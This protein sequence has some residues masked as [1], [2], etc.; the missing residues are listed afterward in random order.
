[1]AIGVLLVLT[2]SVIAWVLLLG[3]DD[4]EAAVPVGT[5]ADPRPAPV[6]T[7]EL[8]QLAVEQ[9]AGGAAPSTSAPATAAPATTNAAEPSV[10]PSTLPEG[11]A[12]PATMA[13]PATTTTETT[14]TTTETTT[15]TTTVVSDGPRIVIE[16]RREACRFGSDCLVVGFS[17]VDFAGQPDSFDCEFADGSRFTIPLEHRSVSYACATGTSGGSITIEIDGVRSETAVHD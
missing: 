9:P 6:T 17:L 2:L 11:S 3:G 5:L 8:A 14:T 10:A 4:T 1:M 16:P 15:T 7:L 13:S 12:T